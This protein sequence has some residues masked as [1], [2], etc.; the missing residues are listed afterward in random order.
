[1][2]A[3]FADEAQIASA[4]KRQQT[5]WASIASARFD[6]D[7]VEGVRKIGRTHARIGSNLAGTSAATL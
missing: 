3:M 2:R 4:K 1:M 7:Y 5:H 6:D